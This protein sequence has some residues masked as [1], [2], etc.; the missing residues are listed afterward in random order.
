[1]LGEY[2]FPRLS[3]LCR[4]GLSG[5]LKYAS[6]NNKYVFMFIK[7]DFRKKRPIQS[8]FWVHQKPP[9]GCLILSGVGGGD[10]SAGR[11][12]KERAGE[13]K[14]ERERKRGEEREGGFSG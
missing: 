2:V 11:N 6:E 4:T 5:I 9:R 10:E 14:R 3:S 7:G 8:I 13:R 12:E 1:M